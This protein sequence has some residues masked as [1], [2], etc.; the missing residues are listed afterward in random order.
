MARLVQ[1]RTLRI[2]SSPFGDRAARVLR[3]R[4]S[5]QRVTGGGS[6]CES[7]AAVEVR[8]VWFSENALSIAAMRDEARAR[9]QIKFA[10]DAP[11]VPSSPRAR[12]TGDVEIACTRR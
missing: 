2:Q 1:W 5:R 10:N 7:G 3:R 8:G 11:A 6:H 12:K 9:K 4:T